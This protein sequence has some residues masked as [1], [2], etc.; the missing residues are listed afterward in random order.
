M[1]EDKPI[2]DQKIVSPPPSNSSP[3]LPNKSNKKLTAFF[4][5]LAILGFLVIIVL[6]IVLKAI[7]PEKR[8]VEAVVASCSQKC[9]ASG[10][11]SNRCILKCLED[12]KVTE[13]GNECNVK[14]VDASDLTQCLL[15]YCI[16]PKPQ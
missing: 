7:N 11:N 9:G 3:N 16:P 2:E 5:I 4:V 8:F 10:D 15:N 1:G 12:D 13:P 6:P 14:C